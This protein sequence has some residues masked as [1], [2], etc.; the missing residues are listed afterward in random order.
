MLPKTDLQGQV[1]A[2]Q[3]QLRDMRQEKFVT[4]GAFTAALLCKAD[5]GVIKSQRW[6]LDLVCK[7]LIS[8]GILEDNADKGGLCV[9]EQEESKPSAVQQV[10]PGNDN[11]AYPEECLAHTEEEIARV[12]KMAMSASTEAQRAV[13]VAAEASARS[14]KAMTQCVH[15]NERC[16]QV[17]EKCRQAD[18]K[19]QQTEKKC[20]DR[21][22]DSLEESGERI[23]TNSTRIFHLANE[24]EGLAKSIQDRKVAATP[25]GITREETGEVFS[26]ELANLPAEKET[27]GETATSTAAAPPQQQQKQATMEKPRSEERRPRRASTTRSK[28]KYNPEEKHE[29]LCVSSR[30]E[31]DQDHHAP[32]RPGVLDEPSPEGR[33]DTLADNIRTGLLSASPMQAA[34]PRLRRHSTYVG[35]R[36]AMLPG[37]KESEASGLV[38]GLV[39]PQEDQPIVN[40][41]TP[42]SWARAS[43]WPLLASEAPA[44]A[45]VAAAAHQ[46]HH[47]KAHREPTTTPADAG[48]E[49]NSSVRRGQS[50][51]SL[52]LELAHGGLPR[53]ET[54][55]L[56]A[57]G[58]SVPLEGLVPASD[59]PSTASGPGGDGMT[60]C[61]PLHGRTATTIGEHTNDLRPE[62]L[63][64]GDNNNT[65]RACRSEDLSEQHQGTTGGKE[66]RQPPLSP[67]QRLER[68]TRTQAAEALLGASATAVSKRRS[69]SCELMGTGVDS[70]SPRAESPGIRLASLGGTPELWCPR[71]TWDDDGDEE[72]PAGSL[73][74]DGS[75]TAIAVEGRRE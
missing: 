50:T 61:P 71:D 72:A 51:P 36:A 62:S 12:E 1:D 68:M 4:Q 45:A 30:R 56:R 16:W 39:R 59:P 60:T 29:E 21:L 46:M 54:T 24:I 25:I 2:H 20:C 28:T 17:E 40:Q 75:S 15:V 43:S 13:A 67:S 3:N 34:P 73:S 48:T 33:P 69:L 18:E 66:N 23:E 49:D 58:K 47:R 42:S 27:P 35:R 31:G 5:Q 70:L 11:T 26:V 6:K 64:D 55:K 38:V 8:A 63:H 14:Q 74:S 10:A 19:C 65:Q 41:A 9:R 7:L 53:R 37:R 57:E 52:E 22:D 32:C 44:A